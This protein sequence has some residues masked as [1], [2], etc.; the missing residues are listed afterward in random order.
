VI[1]GGPFPITHF[2]FPV[3]LLWT[4]T[5]H[6]PAHVA[7]QFRSM[8]LFPDPFKRSSLYNVFHAGISDGSREKNFIFFRGD[9]SSLQPKQPQGSAPFL[10]LAFSAKLYSPYFRSITPHIKNIFWFSP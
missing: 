6:D 5:H 4:G 9:N 8:K 2:S 3:S 10:N 7:A 1:S